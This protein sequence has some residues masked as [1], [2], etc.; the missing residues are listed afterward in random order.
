MKNFQLWLMD[1][2]EI[3]FGELCTIQNLLN[4]PQTVNFI[5]NMNLHMDLSLNFVLNKVVMSN[6]RTSWKL[7]KPKCFKVTQSEGW[8][9]GEEWWLI[10]F[11]QLKTDIKYCA[12]WAVFDIWFSM[13]IKYCLFRHSNNPFSILISLVNTFYK[14][15]Y[16]IILVNADQ[17]ENA[18]LQ[19]V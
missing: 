14:I 2:S 12:L 4:L 16:W 10:C 5:L 17:Y 13:K 15:R 8:D 1:H 11:L 18:S 3:Q 19:K 7:L 9:N 6:F